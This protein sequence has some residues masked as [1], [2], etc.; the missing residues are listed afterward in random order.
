MEH[1]L[2]AFKLCGARLPCVV[3]VSGGPTGWLACRALDDGAENSV[4]PSAGA[5]GAIN[6]MVSEASE[7]AS[8]VS[9]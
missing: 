2:A 4:A 5:D 7:V 1:F 9:Y 3:P 6:E 8:V